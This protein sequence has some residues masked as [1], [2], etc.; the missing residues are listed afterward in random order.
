[1]TIETV[2]ITSQIIFNIIASFA[3][4]LVSVFVFL[5]AYDI[6]KAIKSIKNFLDNVKE[7]SAKF[8]EHLDGFMSLISK[9][10]RKK[11]T[12]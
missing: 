1:M 11:K 5:I 6:V 7:K 2:L 12:K 4:I 9:F 8:Y 10:S 3:I